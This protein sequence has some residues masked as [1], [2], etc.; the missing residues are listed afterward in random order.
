MSRQILKHIFISQTDRIYEKN[1]KVL[2]Y[3]LIGNF[4]PYNISDKDNFIFLPEN[5]INFIFLH[6]YKLIFIE[7]SIS[8]E[9]PGFRHFTT[10]D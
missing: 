5:F 6:K 3:D 9:Q 8:D 4:I 1:K 7:K 10:T 2:P